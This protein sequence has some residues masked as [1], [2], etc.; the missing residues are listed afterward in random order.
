MKQKG[1]RYTIKT[2]LM[3]HGERLPALLDNGVP[4]FDANMYAI[5]EI[6]GR[7]LASNTI[8]QAL[9]AVLILYIF[10][11]EHEIDLME[12][13]KVGLLLAP[14]EIEALAVYCRMPM[15]QMVTPA[16]HVSADKPQSK[17][18]HFEQVRQRLEAIS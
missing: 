6:R 15:S 14:N 17:I 7:N 3:S 1:N 18:I 8:I 4:L 5:S 12:R 16:K 9:R 13:L 11:D 2:V 10:L